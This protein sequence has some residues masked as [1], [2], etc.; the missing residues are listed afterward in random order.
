MFRKE[1]GKSDRGSDRRA[2]SGDRVLA[3]KGSGPVM[4]VLQEVVQIF[5]QE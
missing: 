2:V 3:D 4:A 5:I 1:G